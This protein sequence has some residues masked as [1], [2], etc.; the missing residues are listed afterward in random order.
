M[1]P[2]QPLHRSFLRSLVAFLVL[3][4]L[5]HG[6]PAVAPNPQAPTL[7]ISGP[8]GMQRGT[9]LE[10]LFTGTNLA[11]PTQFWTSFPARVTIPTDNNNGKDNAKLRVVLEVPKDAPLGYHA[12][13]LAT[14]R[15]LSN[16]RLFCI[17]DLPQVPEVETNRTRATAQSVPVPCVVTG[18]AD[19]EASDY[20]KIHVRAGE[21]VS[22]EILGRRLG[23]AFDPQL[24]LYEAQTGRDLPGGHANDS[25]G[26]QTD[27]RL[28]YTF[29]NAGDYVV[30]VRDVLYRG[31]ADYCYRLRIGDFPCATTTVPMA[32]RR[33]SRGSVRF[34][35]PLVDGVPPVEVVAPPEPQTA[36]VWV[37][38]QAVNGLSGWPVP[39]ALSDFDELVEQEP[40]NEPTKANR[41][42]VPC[43]VTG[44]FQ[45]SA[46][47]DQ[48]V[49]AAKKGQRLVIESQTHEFG[50]PTE[51]YLVLRDAKGNQLAAS[52]P[53]AA[54]R[55]DF[56]P[57]ADGDYFLAVEHLLYSGG[58]S[59]SYR[60]TVRP[61]EPGFSLALGL[62]RF[63]LPQGGVVPIG[64]FATRRDYAG[65]I[66]VSLIGHAGL[67]G[68]L[69]I[70]AGQA[71]PPNQPTGL[72]FAR[73]QGSPSELPLGVY[74]CL[75]QGK[76]TVGGKELVE[77]ASV[78][79]AV[80][81]NL[82][83][84]PFPPPSLLDQV[85]IGV[86]EKPPFTLAARL[87]QPEGIRGSPL[88]LT[89]VATR[90][91]GFDEEISIAALNLPPNV[92]AALK[93][94]PKGQTEVQVQLNPAANAPLGQFTLAF[95]GKAKSQNREFSV[96]SEPLA[97]VLAQPFELKV[98][99]APLQLQP[100]GKAMLK[101]SARRRGGY[102][103]PIALEVRN[104]PAKVSS[105]KANLGTGQESAEIE[106]QA[107]ADAPAGQKADVNVLGT[108]TG[109]GNQQ[110]ASP[111]FV[112]AVAGK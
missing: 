43:G 91:Q 103:G 27:A 51:V 22:F 61:Y 74:P 84:L 36:C 68:Q 82:G 23:S 86:S 20:F 85:A 31:G 73:S 71:S 112:I 92:A 16:F 9:K 30:E 17:D 39:L 55:I 78:R 11:D 90:A 42:P 5:A 93:N 10:I 50:S 41:L 64:V 76:A 24:T 57:P 75:V 7:A 54:S 21:R 97:P 104:L 46:D 95:T 19:A 2:R 12:V 52:N 70:Q 65:P 101:V 69:T 32:A 105:A 35:G 88:K 49:F 13:R 3:P 72:L 14:T 66:E 63:D 37:T 98:E 38:P 77:Y 56:T 4:L 29:K 99:P 58:P 47:V 1:L 106:V 89:L 100:G 96:V 26:L 8:C 107:A 40:N 111:N 102:Q 110:S 48:F 109:A 33:G 53:A 80:S 87:D 34:A 15:G 45:E 25:P 60:I 6:Q 62:D 79:A 81:Q 28:T 108:A 94:I 59:E 83:N 67:G 18:R 44:R